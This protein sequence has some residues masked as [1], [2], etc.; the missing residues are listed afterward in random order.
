MTVMGDERHEN[1]WLG[2]L[3]QRIAEA[4]QAYEDRAKECEDAGARLREAGELLRALKTVLRLDHDGHDHDGRTEVNLT[5]RERL[6]RMAMENKDGLLRTDE[7]SQRLADIGL[8][9][10]KHDAGRTIFTVVKRAKDFEKV[11]KGTWRYVGLD[12]REEPPPYDPREERA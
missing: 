11:G 8:Y 2:R 10:S 7:A 4:E 9:P 3:S 5:I 12:P 6:G 1:G